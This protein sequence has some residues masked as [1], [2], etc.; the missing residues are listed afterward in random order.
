MI[1]L[2]H[3]LTL[4]C[5]SHLQSQPYQ[6][7][8]NLCLPS[9]SPLSLRPSQQAKGQTNPLA[10]QLMAQGLYNHSTIPIREEDEDKLLPPV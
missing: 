1:L 7:H 2:H 4:S 5:R 3:A 8:R 9:D 10:L 6:Q